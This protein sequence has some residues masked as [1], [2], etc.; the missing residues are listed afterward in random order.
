MEV[1]LNGVCGENA[2]KPVEEVEPTE[3]DDVQ[4]HLQNTAEIDALVH[5]S[6]QNN[7]E[8]SS[9]Q[10]METG[11]LLVLTNLAVNHAVV[12]FK[13][14]EDIVTTQFHSTMVKAVAEQP[15]EAKHVTPI[16]AQLMVF[17]PNGLRFLLAHTHA[18]VECKVD[19]VNVHHQNMEVNHAKHSEEQ[20]IP[21]NATSICV[22]L[23]N[24]TL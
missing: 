23:N 2:A 22:Q 19:N 3:C 15:P 17:T 21:V 10:S 12:V 11:T 1:G 24:I 20:L 4:T 7:A 5:P 6:K 9:V 14:A 8:P 16:P 18:E 13:S